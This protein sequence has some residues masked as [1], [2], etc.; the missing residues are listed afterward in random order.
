MKQLRILFI[1][2]TI[3]CGLPMMGQT[4]GENTRIWWGWVEEFVTHT[5]ITN[6]N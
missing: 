4:K 5:A 6:A 3:L 2:G 1:I